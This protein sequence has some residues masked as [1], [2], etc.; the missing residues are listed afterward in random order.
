MVSGRTVNGSSGGTAGSIEFVYGR[1]NELS[2]LVNATR[3]LRAIDLSLYWDTH[4]LAAA[5]SVEGELASLSSSKYRDIRAVWDF[6]RASCLR[7]HLLC[8]YWL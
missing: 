6:R 5:R 1:G 3:P 2:F 4:D 8:L 7:R